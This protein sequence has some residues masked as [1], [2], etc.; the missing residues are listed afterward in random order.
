[1]KPVA[2]L[3]LPPTCPPPIPPRPLTP[4]GFA[5]TGTDDV[6]LLPFLSEPSVEV[7]EP[8]ALRV[9][10]QA[11]S[12]AARAPFVTLVLT[13]L[14]GGLVTL[15]LVNTALSQGA[16]AVQKLQKTNL[17][18]TEQRQ[19]L[20]KG[21]ADADQP[22][23]LASRAVA[24]GMVPGGAPAFLRLPDGKVMGTPKVAVSPP[25]PAPS[26][27]MTPSVTPS[28]TPSTTPS[29]TPSVTPSAATTGATTP[30]KG[31]P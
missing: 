19:E 25:P 21:L 3:P 24:L 17:A 1:M 4:P 15:L 23:A 5:L 14:G 20:S 9:V 11:R 28:V 7:E 27:T 29:T 6:I 16:F 8:A 10:P 2:N 12:R 31:K 13:L 30:V 18:L 26:P 22:N